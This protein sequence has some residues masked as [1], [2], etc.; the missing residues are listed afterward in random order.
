[1]WKARSGSQDFQK[2]GHL[3]GTRAQDTSPFLLPEEVEAGTKQVL[4]PVVLPEAPPP[5]LLG[6]LPLGWAGSTGCPVGI[7][8]PILGVELGWGNEGVFPALL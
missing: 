3:V 8:Q 7:P 5:G 1:M 6:P 4:P 2:T